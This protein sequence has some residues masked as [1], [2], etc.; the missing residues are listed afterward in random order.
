MQKK[1]KEEVIPTHPFHPT[2]ST[3]PWLY[4]TDPSVESSQPIHPLLVPF[5]KK[6][7][8]SWSPHIT[9]VDIVHGQQVVAM[10]KLE[11][12]DLQGGGELRPLTGVSRATL[13]GHIVQQ[14]AVL[15][16]PLHGLQQVRPQVHLVP[17]LQLL[18]L[19]G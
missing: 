19:R 5:N 8:S 14:Q 12:D 15:A 13:E 11:V 1:R 9:A 10:A 7:Q 17:Q 16:D 3:F 18:L 2:L 6:R 4:F